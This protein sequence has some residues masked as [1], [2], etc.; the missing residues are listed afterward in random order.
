MVVY[1]QATEDDF[2][3]ILELIEI[4][5]T[6]RR[7]GIDLQFGHEHYILFSYLY[8]KTTNS[9]SQISV[10]EF[11]GKIVAAVGIIPQRL[12]FKGEYIEVGA[13]SPVV[14]HPD[15]QGR[16]FAAE[17][18][19]CAE[20]H[21]KQQGISMFF[22][23]GVPQYYPKYGYIPLLARYKTKLAAERAT[24]E[25][26]EIHGRWREFQIEDAERLQEL[27]VSRAAELW[28]QPQRDVE[29][30]LRL[31]RGWDETDPINT[32]VP[33]TKKENLRI[34]ENANA[35]IIGYLAFNSIDEKVDKKYINEGA[36]VD[37]TTA[38]EM[39][40]ALRREIESEKTLY[41]NGTP[42]H[43]L[44]KAAYQLGGV[45]LSPPPLAGMLKII[46]WQFFLEKQKTL[47]SRNLSDINEYWELDLTQGEAKFTLISDER[48]LTVQLSGGSKDEQDILKCLLTKI[49][50]GTATA[51]EKQMFGGSGKKYLERLFPK[52]YPFIW[53]VNYLY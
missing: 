31:P 14:S 46:D 52:R 10:A 11:E 21:W 5:F 36:A 16:H 44:N 30:W 15:Y 40:A 23:W 32:E 12:S 34:W 17:C 1:R 9:P 27:Y 3:Q 4:G 37:E 42:N 26:V 22:L 43:F 41:I 53:D 47:W 51:E 18:L 50:F 19:K 29:W 6:Q 7:S 24:I 39:I 2:P 49:I 38:M 25:D 20:H 33:F 8:Q 35:E 48:G 13:V 28:L 45:H